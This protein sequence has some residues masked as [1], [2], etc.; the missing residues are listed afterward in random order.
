MLREKVIKIA[1]LHLGMKVKDNKLVKIEE[2]QVSDDRAT[3]ER[4]KY[5]IGNE[6]EAYLDYLIV[7]ANLPK[8]Q[9]IKIVTQDLGYIIKDDKVI[10]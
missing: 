1:S 10:Q 3:L 6:T 8:E 4:I 7:I 5:L 2:L 9:I